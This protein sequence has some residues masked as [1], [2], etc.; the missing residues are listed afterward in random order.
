[1]TSAPPAIPARGRYPPGASSHDLDHHDAVVRLGGRVQPVDRL[2]ADLHRGV[3]ADRDVRSRDVVVDRLRDADDREAVLRM[4]AMRD[5][6]RPLAADRHHAVELE[7]PGVVEDE[8]DAAF[9]PEAV[10]ARRA[11]D[12]PAAREDPADRPAIERDGVA[13]RE[14]SKAVAD[15]DD[16][17]PVRDRPAHDRADRRVEAGAVAATGEDSERAHGQY[18]NMGLPRTWRTFGRYS[19]TS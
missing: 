5:R 16:F 9:L 7:G 17:V 10:V 1:M 12:R 15:A 6:Q 19:S 3:E 8:R 2:R 4:E 18:R 14:A 11:E 13:F